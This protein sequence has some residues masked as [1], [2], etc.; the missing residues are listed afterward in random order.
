[1][2]KSSHEHCLLSTI[3]IGIL[4]HRHFACRK[5][6]LSECS[7]CFALC[8]YTDSVFLNICG[9]K[10]TQFKRSFK[11]FCPTE[12]DHCTELSVQLHYDSI[13]TGEIFCGYSIDTDCTFDLSSPSKINFTRKLYTKQ[14]WPK[15]FNFIFLFSFSL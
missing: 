9:K 13:F 6:Q 14:N 7:L 1:M 15:H 11:I 4:P 8:I 12:I 10:I 2:I 5:F 3:K